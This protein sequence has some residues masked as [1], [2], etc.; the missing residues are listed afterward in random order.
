MTLASGGKSRRPTTPLQTLGRASS[1]NLQ[2]RQLSL[3]F[4]LQHQPSRSRIAQVAS[5][6][7]PPTH[8]VCA[9]LLHFRPSH[10]S[11]IAHSLAPLNTEPR[12]TNSHTRAFGGTPNILN[13]NMSDLA[14]RVTNPPTAEKAEAPAETAPA[15]APPA[16]VGEDQVD[17]TVEAEGGS[18]LQEPDYEVEVALSDLQNNEATPFHSAATWEDLGL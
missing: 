5:C 13:A 15:E 4:F 1:S 2:Q 6:V 17:G 12:H 18:G 16:A 7:L 9:F 11:E 14:D 8:T 10:P 3:F